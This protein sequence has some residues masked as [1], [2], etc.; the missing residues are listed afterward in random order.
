MVQPVASSFK[1]DRNFTVFIPREA[2]ANVG[3]TSF[4][5]FSV[6]LVTAPR[7]TPTLTPNVGRPAPV[8]VL[9]PIHRAQALV[10]TPGRGR[11]L[12][13][14]KDGPVRDIKWLS[15]RSGRSPPS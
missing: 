5:L 15:S 6:K 3:S 11:L 12:R 4:V 2:F 7:F 9:P 1:F 10:V 13:W 14:V 8:A